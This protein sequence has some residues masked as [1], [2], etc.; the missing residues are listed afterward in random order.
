MKKDCDD[1]HPYL[2]LKFIII[3]L[4]IG[5]IVT[6]IFTP[7][8]FDVNDKNKDELSEITFTENNGDY[9]IV[10]I[11]LNQEESIEVWYDSDVGIAQIDITNNNCFFK[12]Y[13]KNC[14]SRI[15]LTNATNFNEWE[16]KWWE[17]RQ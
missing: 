3:G 5:V 9:R 6:L 4:A 11:D 13:K 14:S 16:E 8:F 12:E 17:G 7:N 10:F 15:F 1:K 2:F